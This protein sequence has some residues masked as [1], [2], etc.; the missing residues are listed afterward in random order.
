MSSATLIDTRAP[1]QGTK[2]RLT[3][4]VSTSQMG[5]PSLTLFRRSVHTLIRSSHRVRADQRNAVIERLR[6]SRD[7][8]GYV[9]ALLEECVAEGGPDGLDI[10][11]DVLSNFP[12]LTL[13]YARE[14]WRLDLTRLE[15]AS[16]IPRHH[17]NDDVWYVLLRSAGSS[18]MDT[19]QKVGM[20]MYFAADGP[21]S[22]REASIHALGDMG[23]NTA[24]RLLRR[25][26]LA[27]THASVKETITQ[28]LDDLEG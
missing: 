28:V 4:T 18:A 1:Y 16:D 15:K 10:V 17:L 7:P 26:R 3:T 19:F 2:R 11:I 25:L 13:Q 12:E 9:N 21:E 14:F 22:V 27:E 24:I 23:G 8:M 5:S 20:L 6:F